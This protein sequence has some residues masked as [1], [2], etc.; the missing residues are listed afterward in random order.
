[1][2]FLRYLLGQKFGRGYSGGGRHHGGRRKGHHEGYNNDYYEQEQL[3]NPPVRPAKY[4]QYCVS[5]GAGL[6]ADARFCGQ[7]GSA[8]T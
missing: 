7:C 2:G 5:C 6:Q 4:R 8:I 1:M 3:V